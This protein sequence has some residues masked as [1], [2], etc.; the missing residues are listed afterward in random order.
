M[1]KMRRKNTPYLAAADIE[2][3]YRF[4]HSIVSEQLPL[5]LP[6]G[7]QVTL[8]LRMG[9]GAEAAAVVASSDFE[10]GL[11]RDV[12]NQALA[13]RMQGLAPHDPEDG[14]PGLQ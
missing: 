14:G 10:M 4:A 8:V 13:V 5:V 6:E 11:A 2:H 7:V 12:I 1:G 3:L 9:P